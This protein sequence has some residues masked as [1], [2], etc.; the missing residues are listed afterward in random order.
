MIEY[1]PDDFV[2]TAGYLISSDGQVL[3]NTT[4][5]TDE[6]KGPANETLFIN[7][8]ELEKAIKDA[9]GAKLFK[10]GDVT[11]DFINWKP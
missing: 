7:K 11:K 3:K 9:S 5:D 10:L 1:L 8:V 4:R 2:I 6:I